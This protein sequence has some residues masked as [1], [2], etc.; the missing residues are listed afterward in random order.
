MPVG[1]EAFDC[2]GDGSIILVDS[3]IEHI[4]AEEY[5]CMC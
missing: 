4:L 5:A 3:L 1:C 2:A